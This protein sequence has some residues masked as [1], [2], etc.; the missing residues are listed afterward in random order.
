MIIIQRVN[1]IAYRPRLLE[2]RLERSLAAFP[3]IV[4]TGARQ[5]GKTTLARVGRPGEGRRY[6]TLDDPD[7]LERALREPAALLQ[8]KEPLTLDE[9]QKAPGLLT[10]VKRSID[11]RKQV[12]RFLLSGSANLLLMQGVSESLAGR[13]VHL[14]LLPMTRAEQRGHGCAG[15]WGELLSTPP[16][17]W[18][19]VALGVQRQR[20]DWRALAR[21]GGYPTPSLE[22]KTTD[23]RREWFGGYVQTYLERDLREIV[24]VSS[25]PDFRRLMRACCLR[26]GGLVNQSEIARDIGMAQPSV[27]RHLGALEVSHQ[28]V[29]LPAY[30]VN[31]TKRLIKS[32]KLY[33]SDTGL[34]LHL[35]REDAPRG[36]HLENL[37]LGDLQAW[38]E[39]NADPIEICHWRTTTGLEVDFV[40]E[41]GEQLLPI[42]VKASARLRLGDTRGLQAFLDEY[43]EH[44]PAAIVLYTGSEVSWLRD[45]VLAVPW[46]RVM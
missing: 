12:G 43:P 13:A 38:K 8:G 39:S 3:A 14:S 24:S 42:E 29:R 30:S 34:A 41:R 37:V 20:A 31:R 25:L 10:A 28:L 27:H 40:L 36:E 15:L 33:W 21:H 35:S 32:P 16:E 7:L 46:W 5:A 19:E 17:G 26:L 4:L 9:V 11:E 44:A 22:L 1:R 6:L 2:D 23:A 45:R 18:P